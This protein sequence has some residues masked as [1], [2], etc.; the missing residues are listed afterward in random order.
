M[1]VILKQEIEK[2]GS[3]DEIVTVRPG[4]ARNYLIP[5]GL[6]EVATKSAKKILEENQRQRA[7]KEEKILAEAQGIADKMGAL[8]LSIGAKAGE[9]GKIFGSVNSIQIA[10]ALNKA[11]F[12]IDRRSISIAE[13]NIKELGEYTAKVKLHKNVTQD[14]TFE[15][16]GE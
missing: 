10:E 15:V 14:V 6:A 7:H 11:G 1:E 5:Q 9:N 4:Y 2:L 8:K 3:K 13:D 12:E 16:V